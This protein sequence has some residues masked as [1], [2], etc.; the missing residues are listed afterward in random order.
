MPISDLI[1]QGFLTC[2]TKGYMQSVGTIA[3][4]PEFAEYQTRIANDLAQKFH[5]IA[6]KKFAAVMCPPG[7]SFVNAFRYSNA[8]ILVNCAI[9]TQSIRTVIHG[10]ERIADNNR[11]EQYFPLRLALEQKITKI[12]KILLAF[13]AIAIESQTGRIPTF[14]RFIAKDD[15]DKSQKVQLTDSIMDS[16][17]SAL[18]ELLAFE[19]KQPPPEIILNRHCSECEFQTR[20]RKLAEKCD[21]LSLISTMSAKERLKLNDTGIFTVTQLS[22]TFHLRRNRKNPDS[23]YRKRY[24]ALTALAIRENKTHVIGRPNLEIGKKS[25]FLDVEG[26][27]AKDFYYLIG[28]CYEDGDDG[29]LT[30]QYYWADDPSQECT[31]WE[32]F[33]ATL[34]N[35]GS[36][37]MVHYGAYEKEFLKKMNKRHSVSEE[38]KQFIDDLANNSCNVLSTIYSHIYFPVYSNGLK[39]VGGY[40]GYTWTVPNASGG[41]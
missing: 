7:I 14:G 16:A 30:Y 9:R 40:C 3:T 10:V 33:V 18:N 34:K 17:R 21:D 32:N 35:I 39:A 26:Y 41:P 4:E 15:K 19:S 28:F 1:L 31:I 24:N 37:T 38:T 8:L 2:R 22:Y 36:P 6:A 23:I 12:D 25:I 11:T 20:C 5:L 13:D 29:S 27:P